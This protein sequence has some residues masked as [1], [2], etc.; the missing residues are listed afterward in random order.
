VESW[1]FTRPHNRG[2]RDVC[3]PRSLLPP[4]GPAGQKIDLAFRP[5][6]VMPASELRAGSTDSRALGVGLHRLRLAGQ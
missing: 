3:V 1:T 6:A 4:P 2:V 5:H